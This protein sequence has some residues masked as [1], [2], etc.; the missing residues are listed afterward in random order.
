MPSSRRRLRGFTLIE[1]LFEWVLPILGGWLTAIL[2]YWVGLRSLWALIP[3]SLVGGLAFQWAVVWVPLRVQAKW[4][5]PPR[6]QGV[7]AS[8]GESVRIRSTPLTEERGVAGLTGEVCGEAIASR[9]GVEI[10][11]EPK[12]DIAVKVRCEQRNEQ[13]WLAPD[14]L[15]FLDRPAHE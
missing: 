8:F 1:L 7:I 4:K 14:L 9:A 3:L 5:G 13:L 11:G 10:I 2:L 15:D 12:N 6:T